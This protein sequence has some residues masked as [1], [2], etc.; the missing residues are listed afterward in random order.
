MKLI[1]LT[2]LTSVVFAFA[3]FF[4]SCEKIAEEKKTTDYEKT[5]IPMTGAKVSPTSSSTALGS[6]NIS[7]SK[8]TRTLSYSFN[9]SG[10]SGNP[11]GIG[12]F[13]L[14]PEGYSVPPT[15]PVQTISTSG[16]L[17]TGKYS[18]TLLADGAVI[19]EQ[20]LLNGMYYIQIRTAAYPAGEIRAQIK[21][22]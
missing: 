8:E 22:Q 13:G 16:L 12:V 10:L 21:F 6:L 17:A 11:T 5:N 2:A 7:Y 3:I 18:G 1:R 4:I 20:D 14:A 19:K 9:W 15:T